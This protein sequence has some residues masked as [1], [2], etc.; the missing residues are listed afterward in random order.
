MFLLTDALKIWLILT[1]SRQVAISTL[2]LRLTLGKEFIGAWSDISL[3]LCALEGSDSVLFCSVPADHHFANAVRNRP[4][5]R[6]TDELHYVHR[7]GHRAITD[8]LL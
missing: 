2:Y 1:P 6:S 3:D 5:L 8:G 4:R 7:Y